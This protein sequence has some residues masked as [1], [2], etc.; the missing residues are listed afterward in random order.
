MVL[1]N[2]AV[3]LVFVITVAAFLIWAERKVAARIQ[4]RLGPTRVGGRFGWLQSVADAIK[5][6][7]KEDIIPTQA[8]PILFRTA[9]YLAFV[10]AFSWYIALPFSRNLVPARLEVAALFLLAVGSLEIYAILLGGYASGSKW[11][12]IGGMRE[13]V[14]VI[15][16]EIP[17]ALCLAVPVILSGTMDLVAIGE[18]QRGGIWSWFMFRNPFS[19]LAFWVY[20]TAATAS[21]NRAPFDLPEAE[22]ELVSGYMTEYSGFRWGA[23]MLSEYIAMFAISLLG[24]IVFLGAWYGPIPLT[25]PF[26]FGS[27]S[28]NGFDDLLGALTVGMKAMLGVIVMIWVRWSLPRLRIDHVMTVCL[29]YCMPLAAAAF[30]GTLLWQTVFS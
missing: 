17:L 9:P 4:D 5:V 7:T 10:A 21:L 13:A 11:S 14:Q 27:D 3:L 8:D 12:L 19:F 20:V 25:Q 6:L 30:V 28:A 22:S 15:S 23:F 26:G 1:V 16:Y 24:A 2:C 18:H 29:K